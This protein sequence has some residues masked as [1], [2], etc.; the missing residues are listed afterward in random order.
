MLT[1][2]ATFPVQRLSALGVAEGLAAEEHGVTKRAEGAQI[3][4]AA[5]FWGRSATIYLS[6]KM[7]QARYPMHCMGTNWRISRQAETSSILW[8]NVCSN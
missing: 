6:Y 3:F 8:D 1:N 2:A 4:R 7:M 5:Q